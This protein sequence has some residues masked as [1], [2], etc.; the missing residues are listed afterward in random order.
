MTDDGQM[1]HSPN[2]ILSLFLDV[3][4]MLVPAAVL[5]ELYA[6]VLVLSVMRQD[7]GAPHPLLVVLKRHCG[8]CH[9]P[10]SAPLPMELQAPL[11]PAPAAGT[12]VG[13]PRHPSF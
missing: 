12:T 3:L 11:P 10:G 2:R 5:C 1:T 8:G 9:C 7:L 6:Q 4:G 13:V